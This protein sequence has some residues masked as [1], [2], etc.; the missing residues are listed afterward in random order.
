MARQGW[1]EERTGTRGI[2]IRCRYWAPNAAG[3]LVPRSTSF[4]AWKHGGVKRARELATALLA[5]MLTDV[6]AGT[7]VA[8]VGTTLRELVEQWLTAREG[9][10]ADSTIYGYRSVCRHL[11]AKTGAIPIQ[12]LTALDLQSLY[13]RLRAGGLSAAMVGLLHVVLNAALAQ[14][15]RW[16]LL[17]RNP[18]AAVTKPERRPAPIRYWSPDESARFLAV[19]QDDP[20]HG[21]LWQL[22]LLTGMRRGELLALRWS[23]VDVARQTITIGRTLTRTRAG[24]LIVGTTTKTPNSLRTIRLPSPCLEPLRRHRVR[25]R[26]RRLAATDWST[27][28]GDLVF[29]RPN[30]RHLFPNILGAAFARAIAAAGVPPITL[31]GMRH[32][33]ATGML[34]A[35]MHPKVVA[36]ILGDRVEVVLRVYSHVTEGQQHD[37]I[38]QLA[39]T[40]EALRLAHLAGPDATTSESP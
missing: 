31:H 15:V 5:K 18:A 11:D 20:E 24:K 19:H 32:S 10:V 16:D 21:A 8:P 9:Q 35:G 4:P 23:D 25:Q 14:A 12:R 17:A 40:I 22:A 33:F 37:A 13:G 38:E 1:I 7:Y 36:E 3:E 29:S 30:G 39:R 6:G 26:E 28:D 2:S 34:I 27:E